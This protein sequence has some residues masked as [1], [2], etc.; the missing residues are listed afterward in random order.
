M[1]SYSPKAA[2]SYKNKSPL[3]L[4]VPRAVPMAKLIADALGGELTSCWCKLTHP[5]NRGAIGAIDEQRRRSFSMGRGLEPTWRKEA[6]ARRWRNGEQPIRR[7]ASRSI[8]R[9]VIVV[10]DGM[11]PGGVTAALR[12]RGQPKKLIG[13]VASAPERPGRCCTIAST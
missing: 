9:I 7:R 8:G 3:V 10:D 13:A 1:H 12:P 6:P 4:A 2:A 5:S 11:S